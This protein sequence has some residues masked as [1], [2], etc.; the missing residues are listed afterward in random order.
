M[1]LIF[2]GPPGAGKGT[3][4]KILEER[5]AFKQ[6]STGDM[7]RQHRLDGTALGQK[8][9]QY[10]DSGQLVPDDVIVEMVEE[11]LAKPGEVLLD[12]FPRTVPQARALDELVKRQGRQVDVVLFEIPL[13]QLE[14]R[15]VGRW[16]NPKTGRVYH[17]KFN[18][19]PSKGIDADGT[20]LVQRDDDK[21]ETIR[22][23][24]EVYTEQTQPLI[25]YYER[26]GGS[27]LVRIDATKPVQEVAKALASGLGFGSIV[28]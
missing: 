25:D 15:L 26:A 20:P 19:P 16:T 9:Q 28:Q 27:S 12:G 6:L 2:L 3:Q 21:P 10:M 17:E 4:A 8:A 7:L 24:L 22:K 14:E 1:D 13:D 11:E 5:Y 23:R 18:P